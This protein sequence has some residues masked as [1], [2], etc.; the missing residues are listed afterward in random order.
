MIFVNLAILQ[1]FL[2]IYIVDKRNVTI[3]HRDKTQM[4]NLRLQCTLARMHL[5][6][7]ESRCVKLQQLFHAVGDMPLCVTISVTWRIEIK[8]C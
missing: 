2:G 3:Y 5:A 6:D 1:L 4:Q 7:H 8:Y